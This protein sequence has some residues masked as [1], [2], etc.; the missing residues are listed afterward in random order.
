MQSWLSLTEAYVSSSGSVLP[1]LGFSVCPGTEHPSW[2]EVPC[3]CYCWRKV[4][5]R[6]GHGHLTASKFPLS[7]TP[8]LPS[9]VVLTMWGAGVSVWSVSQRRSE[10][11][12][13]W[14]RGAALT[15]KYF[16]KFTLFLISIS[17]HFCQKWSMNFGL[18]INFCRT[19]II[20]GLLLYVAVQVS[21]APSRRHIEATS[22]TWGLFHLLDPR[23][24]S[25]C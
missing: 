8:G 13:L 15:L 9:C 24:R 2:Q 23:L 3:V 25:P 16:L 12:T 1:A 7:A 22:V 4:G 20:V 18:C 21:W 6:W 17:A 10:R 11:P 19:G 14:H 5:T